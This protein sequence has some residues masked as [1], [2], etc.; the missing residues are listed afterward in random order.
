MVFCW[1]SNRLKL[2]NAT[3]SGSEVKE[4]TINCDLRQKKYV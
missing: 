4:E 1:Q 3:P 2:T